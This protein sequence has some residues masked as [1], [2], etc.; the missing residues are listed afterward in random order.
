MD[1]IMFRYDKSI[2]SKNKWFD[3][4]DSWRNKYK[5]RN[6][7]DGE[8]FFGSTTFLVFL[9]DAWHFFQMIMISSLIICIILSFNLK[10]PIIEHNI[11]YQIGLFI[12]MKIIYGTVFEL[13]YSKILISKKIN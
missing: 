9:T 11:L 10:I 5:N 7:K 4:K 3:P 1:V 8:A 6:V 13:F 2:F 12:T